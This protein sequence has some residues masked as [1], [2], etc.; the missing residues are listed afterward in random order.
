MPA[1]NLTVREC[2][3]LYQI[4]RAE[5]RRRERQK[6]KAPPFTP[7]PGHGDADLARIRFLERIE[8][9]LKVAGGSDV[10]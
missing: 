9:Y 10:G 4:V 1:I 8:G 5:R 7:K 3:A 6:A 2:R